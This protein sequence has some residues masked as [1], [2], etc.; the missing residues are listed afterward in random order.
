[1][2]I[3]RDDNAANIFR[4]LSELVFFSSTA[5]LGGTVR[6]QRQSRTQQERTAG[7]LSMPLN[8]SSSTFGA[9]T[10]LGII[11]AKYFNICRQCTLPVERLSAKARQE[12]SPGE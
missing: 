11:G 12:R 4:A 1:M 6:S 8:T 10:A 3:L 2:R 9:R 7:G 5:R